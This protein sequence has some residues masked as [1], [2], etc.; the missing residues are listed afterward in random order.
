[1][2]I[3]FSNTAH[4]AYHRVLGELKKR[5]GDGGEHIVIVPDKFTASSERGVIA[6]LG[7]DSVFNVSV[8]S[9][10]RLAEKT[11][12]A[13]I[14]KCLTPQ[15]S[16]LLLAK[17]IERN[18]AKLGYYARAARTT[19]FAE[20]FYAALTAIRNSG[21]TPEKLRDVSLRAPENVR[22]KFADMALIYEEYLSAL[23]ERHSDPS[24][25]LEAFAEYLDGCESIPAHF[26][27]VDFYDFKSPELDV[28]SGLARSALSLTVGMVSG[29][30]EPNVRI[31]C[32]AAARRL[33]KACGGGDIERSREELHPAL[34]AISRRLFSYEPAEKRTE[35]DGK[36]RLVA[37]RTRSEE[38]DFLMR[39]IVSKVAAG[40]RYRDFEVV[41][42]DTDAY[43]AELKSAF[44]RCGIPFFIDTRELLSEQTKTRFLLAAIAAARSGM[45][46][47]EVS[48]FVKNPL[49]HHGAEDGEDEVFRFE[50]YCLRYN[51]DRSRMTRPFTLG[52]NGERECAE[53]VRQ[54]LSEA[55]SPLVFKGEI[56]VEEFVKRVSAFLDRFEDAW[57]AH[58]AKLTETSLYY[59]KCA[60]QVDEKIASLLDEMK[61][62]LDGEG[63]LAHFEKM[64][65]AAVQTVKIALVPTWLDCVYVGNTD[66]RYL[67]GGDI[68]I[69]GA[70]VGKLPRGAEGGAVISERDEEVLAALG[71]G[72]A[73][74]VK[75]RVYSELM[76]VTEIMKRPK[77]TLT[78]CYPE[79]DPSGELRPSVVVS[80]LKGML[81][82][83]G[84]PLK[85]ARTEI[86]P[87]RALSEEEAERLIPA[88]FVTPAACMHEVL[89]GIPSGDDGGRLAAAMKCLSDE[90]LVRVERIYRRT[91]PVGELDSE[92]TAAALRRTRGRTDA[93]RL[94]TY[95]ACPYRHY[96]AY[97]VGLREREEAKVDGRTF[98]VLM[99][100]VLERFFKLVAKGRIKSGEAEKKAGEL[101][102]AAVAEEEWLVS[103]AEDAAV[104]RALAR[105]RAE[106]CSVCRTLFDA[107]ERS[108]YKPVYVEARIGSKELPALR[109]KDE[110]GGVSL[111][112]GRVDRVD[113]CGGKF[114]VVDYKTYKSADLSLSDVYSGK[115]I[116][117]YL[118]MEAIAEDTGMTPVG[119][120][121][122]PLTFDF[123]KEGAERRYK[124]N[125]V[126]DEK[127][128]RKID[129]LFGEEGGILPCKR[130]KDGGLSSPV[131]LTEEEFAAVGKYVRALAAYGAMWIA[132]GIIEPEPLERECLYCDY[133]SI[134]A[135]RQG[136]KG[137]KSPAVKPE[138]FCADDPR[139]LMNPSVG[140][141]ENEER[142][143]D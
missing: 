127:E 115:K 133:A 14:K 101:F 138:D 112:K 137:I 29:E 74:T 15:G 43:K 99:H 95:F 103:A 139:G 109:L 104:A 13:R 40:A 141:E 108:E 122:L 132:N 18:A 7:L 113:A 105:L 23:G 140:A 116:Q 89:K 87:Y 80:E 59:A 102:D 128:A 3:V 129:P 61:E 8:T 26:Y 110:E 65:K 49:F 131:H 51:A 24:T 63:D 73:P 125:L 143:V 117:L 114:Y 58:T 77:G 107:S 10:T 4:D 96:F 34:D 88:L 130:G 35:C 64:F 57:R 48:E 86:P 123:E 124:G 45:R 28:L 62:T 31:Y 94:E 56:S 79:S 16:V 6:T 54:R 82:E 92:G 27:V 78:V 53:R 22:G 106:A 9:F 25:R 52:E 38:I 121:Y 55:L 100:T 50:N 111:L 76:S 46:L 71:A 60:D 44:L 33:I 120:F 2:K 30:G 47:A 20:E 81:S 136:E 135:W 1:M 85:V 32:D 19:G 21:V 69:L 90:D 84:E 5:L 118:Y 36:V 12:G 97:I 67:G 142:Y 119:V 41:L 42:S 39:E 75:E 66:N 11:I 37:A 83:G 98:G 93:S 72:V 17:V 70:N 134:C 68:Y 91:S 126:R